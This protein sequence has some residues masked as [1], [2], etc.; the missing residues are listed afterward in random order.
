MGG[1]VSNCRRE[2]ALLL[3]ALGRAGIEL[4]RHP[5]D[6]ALLRLRPARL[7][8]DLLAR[9]RMH[10][11]A[12]LAL[13]ATGCVSDSAGAP[14]AAYIQAERLGIADELAMPTHSG[15]PA[16]LIA[17]GEAMIS[18]NSATSG[19]YYEHGEADGR[20]SSSDQ[21]ERSNALRDRQGCKRGS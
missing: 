16:W 9:L 15:S 4:A 3:V 19:L 18:C 6:P 2:L 13:L 7:D 20:N 11:A 1:G 14:E 5:T 12:I 17:V 10:K 8:P 21:G